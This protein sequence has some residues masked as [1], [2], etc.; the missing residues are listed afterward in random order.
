[1]KT[2]LFGVCVYSVCVPLLLEVRMCCHAHL[3]SHA[4]DHVNAV[5][6]LS[7]Q[8]RTLISVQQGLLQQP[9][10]DTH[11]H[12]LETTSRFACQLVLSSKVS[13]CMSV[14]ARQQCFNCMSVYCSAGNVLDCGLWETDHLWPT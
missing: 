9:C 4:L 8:L 5:Q 3:P 1:M 14:G 13:I 6:Q 10:R 11:Q 2:D 12:S 7:F